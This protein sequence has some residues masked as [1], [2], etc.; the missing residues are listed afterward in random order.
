MMATGIIWGA[1]RDID[2]IIGFMIPIINGAN[3]M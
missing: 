1:D 3:S 2:R